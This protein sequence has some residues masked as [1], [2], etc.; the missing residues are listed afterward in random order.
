M[1][2]VKCILT[3]TLGEKAATDFIKACMEVYDTQMIKRRVSTL[4]DTRKMENRQVYEI[5]IR[6]KIRRSGF[7]G[8][9]SL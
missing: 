2:K 4:L 9:V 8:E 7:T 6:E 5:L 3:K 1:E